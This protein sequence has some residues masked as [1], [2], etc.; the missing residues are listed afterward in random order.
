MVFSILNDLSKRLC[1]SLFSAGSVYMDGKRW[2]YLLKQDLDVGWDGMR[3]TEI[4]KRILEDIR[5]NLLCM[6]N[7]FE[8]LVEDIDKATSNYFNL[9]LMKDMKAITI[10]KSYLSLSSFIWNTYI[11]CN[12]T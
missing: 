5:N 12:R 11:P 1:R 4:F 10:K 2:I 8:I 3:N 7:N 9:F 6:K